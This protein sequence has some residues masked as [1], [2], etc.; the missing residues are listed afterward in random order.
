MT[1]AG[2]GSLLSERSAR[3]TF[4]DLT[5][6]RVGRVAGTGGSGRPDNEYPSQRSLLICR[7]HPL[8][9]ECTASAWT[10]PIVM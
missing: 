3:S 10:P 2:F 7:V 4:P 8:L 6:F 5:N 9:I 1:I